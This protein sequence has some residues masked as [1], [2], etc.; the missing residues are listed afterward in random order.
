M[1]AHSS[2]TNSRP[3]LA[4]MMQV[5]ELKI[6]FT[7]CDLRTK[8]LFNTIGDTKNSFEL[9]RLACNTHPASKLTTT[10]CFI[11]CKPFCKKQSSKCMTTGSS[12][13]ITPRGFAC[14]PPSATAADP[15]PHQQHSHGSTPHSSALG[16]VLVA[17]LPADG[18]MPV[19]RPCY[20]ARGSHC[21][22]VWGHRDHGHRSSGS[23]TCT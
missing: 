5:V 4:L 3:A 19:V 23:T 6:M 10:A 20:K 17:W 2:M 14:M 16:S 1:W 18:N 22:T 21:T 11:G 12:P 8:Q 9:S 13:S 15:L 7:C